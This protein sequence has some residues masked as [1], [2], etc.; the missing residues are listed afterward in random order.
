MAA[1]AEVDESNDYV[2]DEAAWPQFICIRCRYPFSE[3]LYHPRMPK[4]AIQT[5]YC[6]DCNEEW[7]EGKNPLGH[8]CHKCGDEAKTS[9]ANPYCEP[10]SRL[11][12]REGA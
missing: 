10:C 2:D 6:P 12:V 7:G 11:L 8:Y 4:V 5:P 1:A 3:I 9:F